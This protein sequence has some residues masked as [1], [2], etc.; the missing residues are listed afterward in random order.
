MKDRR[1]WWLGVDVYR[2]LR[3]FVVGGISQVSFLR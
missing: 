3:R 2:R 1:K